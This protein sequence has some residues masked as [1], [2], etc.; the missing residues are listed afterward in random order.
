VAVLRSVIFALLIVGIHFSTQ[1]SEICSTK[2]AS[3]NFSDL[4]CLQD[5]IIPKCLEVGTNFDSR[6]TPESVIEKLTQGMSDEEMFTRLIFAESLASQCITAD[7]AAS[8]KS[9]SI[10]DGIAWA[11]A[12]RVNSKK[13]K[14]YGSG[15]GVVTKTAQF[16]S[17]TGGCDTAK[18]VEF[19][20]PE[21]AGTQWQTTW[22]N[23][24]AA[25]HKTTSGKNP[26]PQVYN[27][28]F[29][30]HFDT[31]VNCAKFKGKLPT[32]AKP[33]NQVDGKLPG[34]SKDDTCVQFFKDK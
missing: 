32:W 21:K 33:E 17:S 9:Q 1:A 12:N 5:K 6:D 14:Q 24:Q 23:A 20:C 25:L 10:A 4:S 3:Q 27:Y 16:R 18:R 19:L 15:R 26:L 22:A 29:F 30:K 2:S 28:F 7:N 8:E 13:D 11:L 31:S 34:L